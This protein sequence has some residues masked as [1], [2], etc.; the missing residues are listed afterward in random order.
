VCIPGCPDIIILGPGHNTPGLSCSTKIMAFIA[1]GSWNGN[2]N[3]YN[4]ATI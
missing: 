2:K 3:V 4:V 1:E